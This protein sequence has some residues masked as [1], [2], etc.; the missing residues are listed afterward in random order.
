MQLQ[1]NLLMIARC[2]CGLALM[3][4]ESLIIF[5]PDTEESDSFNII[6]VS[7]GISVLVSD[8]FIYTYFVSLLMFFLNRKQP[9]NKDTKEESQ[10]QRMNRV[11][12]AWILLVVV[13]FGVIIFTYEI[14][15]IIFKLGLGL[16]KESAEFTVI[17][18]QIVI[19]LRD[20][21]LPFNDLLVGLTVLYLFKV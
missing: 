6:C 21:L 8:L 4:S 14:S 5:N 18:E 17:F 16:N 1:K 20:F 13:N 11:I 2:A 15:L 12:R 7:F 19:V 10:E 9:L 3:I